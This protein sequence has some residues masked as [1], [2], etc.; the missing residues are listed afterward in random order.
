MATSGSFV[1]TSPAWTNSSVLYCIDCHGNSDG[2]E[3]A[4][5]HSSE[6]APLLQ[7]PFRGATPDTAAIL[8]YTCHKYTVYASGVDDTSTAASNFYGSTLSGDASKLHYQ[9]TWVRGFGCESCHVSHGTAK[10]HLI[11]SDIGWAHDGT[12]GGACTNTCHS[13]DAVTPESREY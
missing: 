4:G 10:Y 6:D 11:R 8:C 3:P 7:A 13:T 12:G 1:T 2:G 5:P 9:H